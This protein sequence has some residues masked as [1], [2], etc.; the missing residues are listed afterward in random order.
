[1]IFL[2]TMLKHGNHGTWMLTGNRP[3]E[4]P[5][6]FRQVCCKLILVGRSARLLITLGVRPVQDVIKTKAHFT[7]A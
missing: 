3:R 2:V 5:A 7:F 1:M 6:W 4:G